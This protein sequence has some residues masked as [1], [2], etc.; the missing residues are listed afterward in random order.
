MLLLDFGWRRRVVLTAFFCTI[1]V[2]AAQARP[3]FLKIHVDPAA[4]QVFPSAQH[5]AACGIINIQGL[6]PLDGDYTLLHDK[7]DTAQ[8]RPAWI[9]TSAYTQRGR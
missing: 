4:A 6:G 3:L 5:S 2:K 9:G 1:V 7:L 8:G